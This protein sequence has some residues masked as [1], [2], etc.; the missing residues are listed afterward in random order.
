MSVL[1]F[2]NMPNFR[3]LLRNIKSFLATEFNIPYLY[4]RTSYS[5]EGEDLIL[6]KLFN[7]KKRGVYV[8]VGAHHPFRYSNTYLLYSKGWRG[9]NIDASK[10]AVNNF[11]KTRQDDIN[12]QAAVT[13]K[14]VDVKYYI[15]EDNAFNTIDGKHAQNVIN[16]GQSKLINTLKIRTI[17]LKTIL[18]KHYNGKASIDF[19][20]ID[21]EGSDYNILKS[22][23][24]AKYK[25]KIICVEAINKRGESKLITN[26]LTKRNYI[27]VAK[28]I[29][30][31]I[32]KLNKD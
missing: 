12:I 5:Q 16:S 32:F 20:N 31:L 14:I 21:T 13:D 6:N 7:H 26:Y 11:D 2:G 15:F 29:N 30:S 28:S 3:L 8:D 25:P 17:T 9:I 23:D 19:L 10:E 18:N 27:P 24:W 4:S 22:N 1:K